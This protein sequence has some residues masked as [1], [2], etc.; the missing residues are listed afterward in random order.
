MVRL[1]LSVAKVGFSSCGLVQKRRRRKWI[2]PNGKSCDSIPKAIAI[3]VEIGLLPPDTEIPVAGKKRSASIDPPS[4]P[5][6]KK[7]TATT[8]SPST[9]TN[10]VATKVVSSV[11]KTSTTSTVKVTPKP[12]CQK[13]E[14]IKPSDDS[15]SEP[16]DSLQ[17]TTAP[18]V[19]YDPNLGKLVGW[20]IRV[21]DTKTWR[22]GRILLYDS[23]T[24]KHKVQMTNKFPGLDQDQT[25]WLRLI[26]EVRHLPRVQTTILFGQR[27]TYEYA[28]L[29]HHSDGSIR[30]T[31]RLGPRQRLCVVACNGDGW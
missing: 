18:T 19:H 12:S 26:H 30:C 27:Q 4:A 21:W 25:I 3:S 2:A 9:K 7:K 6:A 10:V 22:D 14:I 24:N 16:D 31:P 23:Y 29:Q 15:E 1:S 5:P 13:V 11:T 8:K 20:R 28:P 17:P